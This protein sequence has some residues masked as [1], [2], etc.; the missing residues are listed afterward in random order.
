MLTRS[1][2][3]N[4]K[5]DRLCA[6]RMAEC[7]LVSLLKC[8]PGCHLCDGGILRLLGFLIQLPFSLSWALTVTE[9]WSLGAA[10]G[11]PLPSVVCFLCSTDVFM[12]LKVNCFVAVTSRYGV[13]CSTCSQTLSDSGVEI[14]SRG[15]YFGKVATRV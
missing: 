4:L 3:Q 13:Y 6:K 10:W 14:S 1:Q 9:A 7:A 15:I 12:P 11:L 8:R 2:P 5:V